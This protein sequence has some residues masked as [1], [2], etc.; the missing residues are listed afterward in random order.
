MGT[1]A[2]MA[3]MDERVASRARHPLPEEET[4]GT[5]DAVAQADAIL[6]ESDLRSVDRSAAPGT[7]LEN[8]TSE[9]VT[10]PIE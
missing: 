2:P 6:G 1:T 10:E 5:D 3:E 4:A 8:R 9:E 7:H